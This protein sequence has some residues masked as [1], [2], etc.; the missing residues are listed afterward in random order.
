MSTTGFSIAPPGAI[1]G[2]P[3]PVKS[4]RPNTNGRK[5]PTAAQLLDQIKHLEAE[6]NKLRTETSAGFGNYAYL[7]HEQD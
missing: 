7:E 2:V 1:G 6:G 4:G 3:S 5:G